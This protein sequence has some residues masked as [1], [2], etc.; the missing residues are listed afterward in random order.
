MT[1]RYVVFDLDDTLVR[2]DAVRAAFASVVADAGISRE[3]MD[4]ACDALPGRP[5]RDIFAAV[6]LDADAEHRTARFGDR[7]EA[8]NAVL[9]AVRY[10]DADATLQALAQAGARLVLSTGSPGSRAADVVARHGWDGFEVVLGSA[11]DCPKGPRHYDRLDAHFGEP[12]WTASAATVGDSPRDM[13]LGARRGIPVRIGVD[14]DGSP[15]PLREAGATH[16]VR[17]LADVVP[18]LTDG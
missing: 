5:A 15:E 14:R 4:A 11:P 8:L 10:P 12:D 6:G 18:I 2:S 16:V 7:L 3:T 9:P 17:T 13:R 1:V